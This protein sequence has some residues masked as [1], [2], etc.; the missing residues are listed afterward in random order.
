MKTLRGFVLIFLVFLISSL[1][2]IVLFLKTNPILDNNYYTSEILSSPRADLQGSIPFVDSGQGF[3]N[4][5]ESFLIVRIL[6]SFF[7]FLFLSNSLI[8][9]QALLNIFCFCVLIPSLLSI[10][11]IFTYQQVSIMI[12]ALFII[13]FKNLI[14]NL[15][16]IGMGFFWTSDLALLSFSERF[17]YLAGLLFVNTS[18]LQIFSTSPR[19]WVMLLSLIGFMGLIFNNNFN[20][21]RFLIPGLIIDF[22]PAIF[23]MVIIV[24]WQFINFDSNV[25]IIAKKTAEYGAI[26][27]SIYM[28]LSIEATTYLLLIILSFVWFIFFFQD[29]M[30]KV[31]GARWQNNSLISFI[32]FYLLTMLALNYV[33]DYFGFIITPTESNYIISVFV[34]EVF[35][36]FGAFVGNVLIFLF[37]M[38]VLNKLKFK[39][40]L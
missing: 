16:S 7:S 37:L 10:R 4:Y 30:V 36:R 19:N 38:F 23:Y 17:K 33:I 29:K 15:F 8:F 27:F 5:N 14:I 2:F 35:I 25:K 39:N 6:K 40:I 32:S 34:H 26:I 12:I 9:N 18:S 11:R 1:N 22:Y 24:F 20:V 21:F 3:L 31:S 13:F 28:L